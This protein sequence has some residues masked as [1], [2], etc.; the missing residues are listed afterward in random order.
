MN[1]FTKY[2][3]KNSLDLNLGY[4][5][6]NDSITDD[7]LV[8]IIDFSRDLTS[9]LNACLEVYADNTLKGDLGKNNLA[10]AVSLAYDFND[11]VCLESGVGFGIAKASPDYQYSMTLTVDF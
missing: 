3:G 2:F 11:Q 5:Y 10:C 7:E 1:I 9:K 8:C 6:Y 4:N